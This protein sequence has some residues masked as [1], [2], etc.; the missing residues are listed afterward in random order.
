MG[1][2]WSRRPRAKSQR[3]MCRVWQIAGTPRLFTDEI[4]RL[5]PLKL[6]G[7]STFRQSKLAE[8]LS[9]VIRSWKPAWFQ[10]PDLKSCLEGIGLS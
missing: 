2:P 3:S 9:G 10:I 6:P 8:S 1:P 7:S 4:S 5:V